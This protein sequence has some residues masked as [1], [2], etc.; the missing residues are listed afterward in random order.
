[1]KLALLA[2]SY[3]SLVGCAAAQQP[4]IEQ[5]PA[6]ASSAKAPATVA[7]PAA[8]VPA[9]VASAGSPV[10]S[11]PLATF[12]LA[13]TRL[14]SVP[15]SAI[16]LG[17]GTRIAVLADMPYVG[18]ARGLR[19]LPLPARL[20]PTASE[21]DQLGIFF[22]RDNEP[23]IMGSRRGERGERAVYLRHL[24]TGWRDGR[25]EIGQ[26]GGPAPGGLWG[27]LGSADP[28][29]VCRTD[30]IC[31]IKRNSGWTTAKAGPVTRLVTLQDGVLWG[32]EAAGISGI[33]AQGWSL[34]IPAPDW[35]EPRAFWATRGE[36]WVSSAHELYHYR[37][38]QWQ[39]VPSPV[40]RVASFWGAGPN[41]LWLVGSGGAAHF[42]GQSF[43][44][45][46]LAGPL[47]VV[48]GRSDSELWFGGD[49]GLF[50]ASP[51]D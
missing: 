11:P 6:N 29:L 46:E 5:A 15:V 51:A 35:S 8:S 44:L 34:A 27:V 12:K 3:L 32:L 33:D 14:L 43:R 1:M 37:S 2:G 47:G 16:A 4:V 45:A 25:E 42:D 48:R 9:A 50:R 10:A 28:E 13:L 49:A 23:R 31:I 39:T 24:Q 41:S 40:G 20:R 26:L 30:A 38:G 21:V 36:A 18:D 19:P 17:E 22:G 7:A